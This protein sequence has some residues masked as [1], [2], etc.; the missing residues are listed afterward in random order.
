MAEQQEQGCQHVKPL[1]LDGWWTWCGE[2]GSLRIPAEGWRKPDALTN[3]DGL[4]QALEHL[5]D[6][7]GEHYAEYLEDASPTLMNV[8]AEEARAVLEAIQKKV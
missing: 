6:K 3:H 7:I 5:T 1:L 8:W 4:V 2:C